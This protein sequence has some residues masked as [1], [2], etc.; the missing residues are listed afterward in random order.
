VNAP[1]YLTLARILA[2]PALVAVMLTNFRGHDLVATAIFVFAS[3]TD[4]LDGYLARKKGQVTVMGQLLDPTADKLLITSAIICLVKLGRVPAWAAVVIIG[5][6][7]A[8]SGF[9]AIA[10]S[11]G[12]NIPA[13]GLGKAKMG[14]ESWAVGAL[15]LGPVY[16]GK[17]YFV[18]QAGLW[19][20]IVAALV[21]A[22]EY[23]VRYGPQ[24][25]SKQP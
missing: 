7:L 2:I 22:A 8:I 5:R 20:V 3:I 19:L 17:F 15:I 21:S 24:V 9:R 11:K 6:E 16:W 4:W 1:N 13:S 10:S 23:Y 18:A 14:I 12:L 25:L